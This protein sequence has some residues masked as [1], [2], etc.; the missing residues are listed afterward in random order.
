MMDPAK[1]ATSRCG[2][3]PGGRTAGR[4]LPSL[5]GTATT[6]CECTHVAARTRRRAPPVL[7]DL[8]VEAARRLKSVRALLLVKLSPRGNALGARLKKR[9]YC[10]RCWNGGLH[11]TDIGAKLAVR[12]GRMRKKR[13]NPW[14]KRRR[15]RRRSL[16][17]TRGGVFYLMVRSRS[18]TGLASYGSGARRC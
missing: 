15:R 3:G 10:V 6:T 16:D 7:V 11:H 2:A 8:P 12:D 1:S 4:R 5:R 18:A 9:P 14:Q 13:R 17:S